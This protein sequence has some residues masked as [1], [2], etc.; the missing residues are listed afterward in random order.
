ML[1]MG[2]TNQLFVYGTL[3]KGFDNQ[4]ATELS[5]NSDYYGTGYFSGELY[6]CDWFP[7]ALYL[8]ESKAKV[9]GEIYALRDKARMLSILDEYE[10][11]AV[12]PENSL[13]IRKVIPVLNCH[14]IEVP[15]YVYLY[16][17]SVTDLPRIYDG[18]FINR[19]NKAEGK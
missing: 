4:F 2:F 18:N 13:Y 10:E 12:E 9:Y 17:Q 16:N 14:N 1:K 15:C 11:I 7:A 8:P 6:L 5:A 19:N 3:K